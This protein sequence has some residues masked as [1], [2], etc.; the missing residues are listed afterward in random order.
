M[1]QSWWFSPGNSTWAIFVR[2]ALA[3]VFIP[4]GL[5]KL[6]H[7]GILG[8]GRFVKIGI[9]WPEF[10]TGSITPCISRSSA[11]VTGGVF[12]CSG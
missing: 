9:P 7:A 11:E 12:A 3:G 6:T 10:C 1:K 8:A 4:E 2:L 5:Q